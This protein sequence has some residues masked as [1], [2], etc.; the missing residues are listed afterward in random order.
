MKAKTLD[1]ICRMSL[2][3]KSAAQQSEANPFLLSFGHSHNA[4]ALTVKILK[5]TTQQVSLG[6]DQNTRNLF[7]ENITTYVTTMV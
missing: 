6:S 7:G 2:H 1:F 3:I 4:T 5:I